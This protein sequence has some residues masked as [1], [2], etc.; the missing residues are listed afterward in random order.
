MG[1]EANLTGRC[2]RVGEHPQQRHPGGRCAELGGDAWCL[3][4]TSPPDG[5]QCPQTQ[6]PSLDTILI[7]FS[8]PPLTVDS[9]PSQ[10]PVLLDSLSCPH[11]SRPVTKSHRLSNYVFLKSLFAFHSPCYHHCDCKSSNHGERRKD[12]QSPKRKEVAVSVRGGKGCQKSQISRCPQ[13]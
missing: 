1:H 10:K 8:M 4:P 6:R 7:L 12:G 2:T 3:R 5:P 9:H 11:P 13:H